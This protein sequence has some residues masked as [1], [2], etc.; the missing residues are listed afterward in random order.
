MV[1]TPTPPTLKPK[2]LTG[3]WFKKTF[4]RLCL[5]LYHIMLNMMRMIAKNQKIKI[6]NWSVNEIVYS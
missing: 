4:H 2:V 3:D 6:Y 5:Q 1:G